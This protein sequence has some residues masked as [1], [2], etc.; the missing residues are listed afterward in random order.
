MYVAF[1]VYLH[2]GFVYK[3]YAIDGENK[4]SDEAKLLFSILFPKFISLHFSNFKNF[5]TFLFS[6][7]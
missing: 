7:Y 2:Q 1:L 6:K 3:I 5:P 4:F